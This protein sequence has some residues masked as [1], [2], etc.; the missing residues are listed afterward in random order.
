MYTQAAKAN[1]EKQSAAHSACLSLSQSATRRQIPAC[2]SLC[3]RRRRRERMH[4]KLRRAESP[5]LC[6]MMSANSRGPQESSF[7]ILLVAKLFAPILPHSGRLDVK[8]SPRSERS[9]LLIPQQQFEE[10]SMRL[11]VGRWFA[12]ENTNM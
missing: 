5:S 9:Q 4:A 2:R 10:I 3:L 12:A 1:N 6:A 8:D 11:S 7:S